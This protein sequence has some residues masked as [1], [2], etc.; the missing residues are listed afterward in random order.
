VSVGFFTLFGRILL[1]LGGVAGCSSTTTGLG[2]TF[3]VAEESRSP[4]MRMTWTGTV[5]G[6]NLARV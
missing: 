5:A 4:G 6:W 3:V 1:P 2:S